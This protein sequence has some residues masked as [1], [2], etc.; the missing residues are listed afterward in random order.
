MSI[1]SEGFDPVLAPVEQSTSGMS[2]AV[3]CGSGQQPCYSEQIVGGTNQIGVHLHPLAATVGRFAQTSDRLHPAKGFL[4]SF[5]DRLADDITRLTGG[6]R[7][8]SG[9]SRPRI[10]LRHVRSNV[11][12][13][14]GGNEAAGVVALIGAQGDAAAARP[15]FGGPRCSRP[16]LGHPLPSPRL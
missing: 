5:A 1:D 4:D 2:S 16:S 3:S 14:T 13:A 9:T 11:E 10:I 8:E 15:S 12:C 7:V 6:A